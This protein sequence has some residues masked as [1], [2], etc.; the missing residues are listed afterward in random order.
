MRDVVVTGDIRLGQFLKRA[1]LVDT[2]AEGKEL[3]AAGEV[4]V[5]EEVD[6]RRGRQLVDGD[7]VQVGDRRVR[8]L[9]SGAPSPEETAPP[10][11]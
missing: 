6:T 5:N 9:T 11:T 3:V 10:T 8:V 7:V 2:G 4:L 1:E